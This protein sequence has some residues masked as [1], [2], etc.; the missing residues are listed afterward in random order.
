MDTNT[1]ASCA[2]LDEMIHCVKKAQHLND[3]ITKTAIATLTI[4]PR[5]LWHIG[6]AH[7]GSVAYGITCCL[8]VLYK[9]S[10]LST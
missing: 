3:K 1:E 8:Q 9:V 4:I 2:A 10:G 6:S 7:G 5:D